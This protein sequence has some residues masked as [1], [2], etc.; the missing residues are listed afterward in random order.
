M[1]QNSLASQYIYFSHCPFQPDSQIPYQRGTHT[2]S[3]LS[4]RR[5]TT[6]FLSHIVYSVQKKVSKNHISVS[7][8]KSK[9]RDSNENCLVPK[10]HSLHLL[11]SSKFIEKGY[12]QA[13][14]DI[15][16]HPPSD[17]NLRMKICR[18]SINLRKICGQNDDLATLWDLYLLPWWMDTNQVRYFQVNIT[19][20]PRVKD[21][22]P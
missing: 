7:A 5:C 21:D 12:F 4:C 22:I 15:V 6:T 20:N 17:I 18:S 10:H 2:G 16:T 1:E 11:H 13:I 19:T 3:L 9:V 8:N 14:P